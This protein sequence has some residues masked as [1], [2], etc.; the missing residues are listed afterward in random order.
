[1]GNPQNWTLLRFWLWELCEN[2]LGLKITA[3]LLRSLPSGELLIEN[4]NIIW[5]Y[6]SANCFLTLFDFQCHDLFPKCQKP[7]YLEGIYKPSTHAHCHFPP[8]IVQWVLFR[9][10]APEMLDSW[11]H[12]GDQ[13]H[14]S[15]GH[16]EKKK[17]VALITFDWSIA[18][19]RTIEKIINHH[20]IYPLA[21]SVLLWSTGETVFLIRD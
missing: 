2:H 19:L 15:A 16:Q 1:M 21:Y 4:N 5:N 3:Y 13:I 18:K 17:G 9:I 20:Y 12:S 7:I 11:L 14:R 10:N 8:D 6:N